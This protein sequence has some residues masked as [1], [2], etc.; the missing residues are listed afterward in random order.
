MSKE[1][2]TQ[3]SRSSKNQ[4]FRGASYGAAGVQPRSTVPVVSLSMT[5]LPSRTKKKKRPFGKNFSEFWSHSTTVIAFVISDVSLNEATAWPKKK[6]L[7]RW[8]DFPDRFG[9][10]GALASH[11]RSRCFNSRFLGRST[12][13][14]VERLASRAFLFFFFAQVWF[15]LSMVSSS[16][17][18][19]ISDNLVIPFIQQPKSSEEI[20]DW[21]CTYN[22]PSTTKK[23]RRKQVS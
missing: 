14:F 18:Q 7:N 19:E 11:G 22:W 16:L 12:H 17:F 3:K 13:I 23:A 6:S 10:R 20:K 2:N 9:A 21:F 8:A 1:P 4:Q 5:Q 15:R